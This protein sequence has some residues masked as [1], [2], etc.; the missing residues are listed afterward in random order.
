MKV[1]SYVIVMLAL[2]AAALVA[3]ALVSEPVFARGGR[4]G[5]GHGAHGGAGRG[6]SGG[7]HHH[8][9]TGVFVG[10]GVVG[11]APW[12]GYPAYGVV[13]AYPPAPLQYI[14]KG[15][16]SSPAEIEWFYCRPLNA[17]FPYVAECPGGWERVAPEAASG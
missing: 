1:S 4:G 3:A 11:F 5:G 12:W 15:D 14:E 9:R 6:H 17:Y 8:G 16:G 7:H 10:A 13:S 2:V